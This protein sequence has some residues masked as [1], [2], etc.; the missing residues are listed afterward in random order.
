[1]KRA[2]SALAT[3]MN[4]APS[5]TRK[6]TPPASLTQT[7]RT[8]LPAANLLTTAGTGHLDVGKDKRR[9][10]S[11]LRAAHSREH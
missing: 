10:F 2:A 8:D 11:P 4:S 5:P 9:L 1:M 6:V 3:L 7:A